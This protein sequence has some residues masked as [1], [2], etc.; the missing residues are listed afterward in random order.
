[1]DDRYGRWSTQIDLALAK[2]APSATKEDKQDLR[3][4]V[5]VAFIEE[6]ETLF[7]LDAKNA[8]EARAYAY[9]IARNVIIG[10]SKERR[11]RKRAR[12]TTSLDDPSVRQLLHN[13]SEFGQ[14][15]ISSAVPVKFLEKMYSA[16]SV[17]SSSVEI[18]IDVESAINRL[19]GAQQDVIR[20]L[21]F[22]GRSEEDVAKELN[23]SRWRVR[24]TKE[25]ALKE[26]K[27][28]LRN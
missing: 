18:K 8:G 22:E 20:A 17:S 23:Q 28:L 15:K 14:P 24:Q 12:V 3:Q 19:G 26:L 4:D 7:A 1:M 9:S 5:L 21:Y 10:G 6:D 16:I 13:V 27:R 11:Q 25:A 2:H